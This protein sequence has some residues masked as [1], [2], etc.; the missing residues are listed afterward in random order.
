M[1]LNDTGRLVLDYKLDELEIEYNS[2]LDKLE[3]DRIIEESNIRANRAIAI[4]K[5]E[6]KEK[7]SSRLGIKLAQINFEFDTKLTLLDDEITKSKLTLLEWYEECKKDIVLGLEDIYARAEDD[8][9][10]Y[11]IS[12]EKQYYPYNYKTRCKSSKNVI[13]ALI[14]PDGKYYI[15]QTTRCLDARIK[16][17]ALIIDN[18]RSKK[19]IAIHK[20]KTF[21]VEVLFKSSYSN[22]VRDFLDKMERL[23]IKEYDSY[24]NGY[25]S[26]IDGQSHPNY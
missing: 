17:H 8:Y 25:N 2:K 18:P 15:G 14:F 7:N 3:R 26:T 21:T 19:E 6:M 11:L 12:D 16:E 4:A 9:T 24:H 13:Y 23:F 10:K 1:E 5:V 20:F 22:N